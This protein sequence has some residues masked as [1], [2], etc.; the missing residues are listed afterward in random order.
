MRELLD[1]RLVMMDFS[2]HGV[3]LRQQLRSEYAQLFGCHL[4]EIG[5]GSHAVDFTKAIH[6]LQLKSKAKS[7]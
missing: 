1:D 4:V 3:D 5:R 2:A 7:L 6:L